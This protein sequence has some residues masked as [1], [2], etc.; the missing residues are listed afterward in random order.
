M[1][2]GL[3]R[4]PLDSCIVQNQRMPEK[5]KK[6]KRKPAC[7]QCGSHK[8]VPVVYGLLNP[9]LEK[10]LKKGRAI[11]GDRH[12]WEGM[13][14]WHCSECGCEWRGSWIRFKK[15]CRN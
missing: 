13:S 5:F 4:L 1:L 2:S 8:V 7:P 3:F 14:E 11:L 9:E 6:T 15:I 12:E 10:T